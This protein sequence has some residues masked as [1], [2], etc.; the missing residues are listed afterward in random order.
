MAEPRFNFD[1]PSDWNRQLSV[2]ENSRRQVSVR[3][4]GPLFILKPSIRTLAVIPLAAKSA[5]YNAYESVYCENRR[6]CC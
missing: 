4:V 6:D 5:L 3:G 1:L 2:L